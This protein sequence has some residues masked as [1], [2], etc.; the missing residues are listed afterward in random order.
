M[1]SAGSRNQFAEQVNLGRAERPICVS[2][3]LQ[4]P[5]V[6]RSLC[7]ICLEAEDVHRLYVSVGFT[8]L[9]ADPSVHGARSPIIVLRD[10]SDHHR[11]HSLCLQP[12][13]GKSQ[14]PLLLIFHTAPSYSSTLCTQYCDLKTWGS[15][16][17]DMVAPTYNDTG[18]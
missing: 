11:P 1:E 6:H 7:T 8:V 17:C 13:R 16:D 18:R 4:P 2:E 3:Q 5:A 14:N 12:D 10:V 9:H 15:P